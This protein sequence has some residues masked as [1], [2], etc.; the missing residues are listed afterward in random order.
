MGRRNLAKPPSRGRSLHQVLL[1]NTL[2]ANLY[3][4]NNSGTGRALNVRTDM[5]H[6]RSDDDLMGH[7]G[8]NYG[9]SGVLHFREGRRRHR[10]LSIGMLVFYSDWTS[11]L[12]AKYTHA[13]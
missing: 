10:S 7:D 3:F 1:C 4:H 9:V 12:L 11:T 2:V 5:R 8:G 6:W 13:Y